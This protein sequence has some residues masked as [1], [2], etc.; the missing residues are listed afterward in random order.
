MTSRSM[1]AEGA[2]VSFYG[3]KVMF[4]VLGEGSEFQD[5]QEDSRIKRE[6]RYEG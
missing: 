6:G 2:S 4:H 3:C 5:R 1:A